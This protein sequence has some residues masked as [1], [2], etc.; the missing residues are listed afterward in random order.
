MKAGNTL[1][2]EAAEKS[3]GAT[4]YKIAKFETAGGV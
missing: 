1:T 3:L 2:K 4:R